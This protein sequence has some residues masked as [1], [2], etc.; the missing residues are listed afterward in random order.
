MMGWKIARNA[1][2]A[3]AEIAQIQW[4]SR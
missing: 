2:R 1:L 4:P 3:Q